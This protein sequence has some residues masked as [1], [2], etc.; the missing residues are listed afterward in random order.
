M[1]W[2]T[3]ILF[4]IVFLNLLTNSHSV[5]LASP[6]VRTELRLALNSRSFSCV[7]FLSAAISSMHHFAQLTSVSSSA[8]AS[9]YP[10]PKVF[11]DVRGLLRASL[12]AGIIGCC[13]MAFIL[14]YYMGA[15]TFCIIALATPWNPASYLAL[16][17]LQN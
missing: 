2:M 13:G 6:E 15:V 9:I 14:M 8:G 7:S 16:G 11:S 3:P 12:F 4:S 17:S 10:E 5:V 1:A